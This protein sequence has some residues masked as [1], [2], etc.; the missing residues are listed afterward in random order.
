MT[1][2]PMPPGLLITTALPTI[3]PCCGHA[4]LQVEERAGG[5]FKVTCQRG[6]PKI[7]KW[8]AGYEVKP[9]HK[10]LEVKRG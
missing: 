4:P 2:R 7:C 1:S 5:W 10:P 6:D 9:D 8:W 3:C